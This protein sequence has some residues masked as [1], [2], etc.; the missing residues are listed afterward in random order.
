[1]EPA[2][3]ISA[4]GQFTRQCR[5][6][7]Q[8]EK[9]GKFWMK[10][11]AD[12][13]GNFDPDNLPYKGEFGRR[14]D[15][16]LSW[17]QIQHFILFASVI[18]PGELGARMKVFLSCWVGS[19]QYK[20]QWMQLHFTS[21]TMS[22]TETK[23]ATLRAFRACFHKSHSW[24]SLT[25]WVM[26]PILSLEGI[27][28]YFELVFK[29]HSWSSLTLWVMHPILSLGGIIKSSRQSRKY[30]FLRWC[31]GNPQ[32]RRLS[33]DVLIGLQDTAPPWITCCLGLILH[34]APWSI[35][36]SPFWVKTS[37]LLGR[38]SLMFANSHTYE[39]CVY[40]WSEPRKKTLCK[41]NK[42]SLTVERTRFDVTS[43]ASP[44]P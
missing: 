34:Q 31:V 8:P 3:S 32:F 7:V 16:T 35:E 12:F 17:H 40:D 37:C 5:D 14:G 24:S 38:I 26:H 27:M 25:L 2:G 36:R 18:T 20:G 29:S 10:H 30:F 4:D 19:S 6:F 1:M 41:R 21:P 39:G 28:T 23:T 11:C 15:F 43:R 13:G 22:P 33:A 9:G 42:H 44:K